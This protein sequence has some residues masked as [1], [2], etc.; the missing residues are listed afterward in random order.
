MIPQQP[1]VMMRTIS[2]FVAT[3]VVLLLVLSACEEDKTNEKEAFNDNLNSFN[4][5]MNKVDKTM[6]VVDQMQSEVDSVE[7]DRALGKIDDDEAI[8]RLEAINTKYSRTI[9]KLANEHPAIT[10]PAWATRL[11]LTEPAGLTLDKDFSQ[12][13]SEDNPEE[14]FN[15]VVMVYRGD[16]QLAMEQAE[17]I[18]SKAGIPMSSDY[19]AAK[20]LA[21]KYGTAVIKGAAY[22][23]FEL[24]SDTHPK[25][26]IAITVDEDGSLTVTATDAKKLSEQFDQKIEMH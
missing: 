1:H 25:Y 22:M 23:N 24:G 7:E 16:Y 11:G 6:D 17:I 2:F 15:S 12:F 5:T 3:L 14:G 4:K 21:E 10:L 8:E 13:T 26:N 19:A 18:A 9:A 20:Q